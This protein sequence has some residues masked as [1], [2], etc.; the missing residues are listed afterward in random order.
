MATDLSIRQATS[1]DCEGI[2]ACLAAAFAPYKDQ[3]TAGAFEDTVLSQETLRTRMAKMHVLVAI[4]NGEIVGTVSMVIERR[5][6]GSEPQPGFCVDRFLYFGRIRG[7]AVLPSHHGQG[8]A[9]SLLQT[10]EQMF[11]ERSCNAIV[12]DTTEPLK[13]AQRFYEKHGYKPTGDARDFFGMEL[14][15]LGKPFPNRIPSLPH[16]RGWVSKKNHQVNYLNHFEP[17]ASRRFV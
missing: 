5:H 7:M 10:A 2:L 17:A 11:A 4:A 16:I 8:I 9:E 12:L 1:G 3:Y 13:R 6:Y 15:E 14:I